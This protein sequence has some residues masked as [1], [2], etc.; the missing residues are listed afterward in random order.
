MGTKATLNEKWNY[1]EHFHDE[2]LLLI[3][4]D[5]FA[6]TAGAAAAARQTLPR[7]FI[8]SERTLLRPAPPASVRLARSASGS[9][10]VA[11]HG[12][13]ASFA[14]LD[15]RFEN[16]NTNKLDIFQ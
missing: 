8:Q 5:R 10:R 14:R 4:V 3:V 7:G 15:R 11:K 6:R 13:A 12:L 9:V 1:A 16:L 2:L